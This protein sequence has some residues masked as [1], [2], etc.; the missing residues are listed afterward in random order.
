M[1]Q[2]TA[3]ELKRQK[4]ELNNQIYFPFAMQNIGIGKANATTKNDRTEINAF[5]ILNY[6]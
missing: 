6:Y 5:N 2:K 1:N 3:W 4:P